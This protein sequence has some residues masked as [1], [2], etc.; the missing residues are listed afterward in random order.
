MMTN[1]KIIVKRN[2][3]FPREILVNNTDFLT[4]IISKIKVQ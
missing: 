3:R 1:F 2:T 4:Y